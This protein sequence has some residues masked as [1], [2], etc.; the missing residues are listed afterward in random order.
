MALINDIIKEAKNQKATNTTKVN[1]AAP[2][3]L[4]SKAAPTSSKVSAPKASAGAT[5]LSSKA[6]NYK[7]SSASGVTNILNKVKESQGKTLTPTGAKVNTGKSLSSVS[8]NKLNPVIDETLRKLRPQE[9][10]SAELK[11]VTDQLNSKYKISPYSAVYDPETQA[12]EK[13]RNELEN[14][15]KL[16]DVKKERITIPEYQKAYEDAMAKGDKESAKYYSEMVDALD[17]NTVERVLKSASAAGRN[18]F[19]DIMG[20][21]EELKDI[22]YEKDALGYEEQYKRALAEGKTE[23]AEYYKK[24][25]EESRKRA[26]SYD[27]LDESHWAVQLRNESQ[28][29]ME[30]E[31]VGAS[32]TDMLLME[33]GDNVAN[34]IPTV[35]ASAIP[36]VGSFSMA[37]FVPQ[38]FSSVYANNMKNGYDI[39]TSASNAALSAAVEFVSEEIGAITGFAI[40]NT[41]LNNVFSKV[42]DT[43]VG[44]M[45]GAMMANSVIQDPISEGNEELFSGVIQPI[46]DHYTLG[47]DIEYSFGDLS[48]AWIMGALTSAIMNSPQVVTTH[49]SSSRQANFLKAE[50]EMIE[51]TSSLE[52]DE[53]IQATN[54]ARRVAENALAEF[55]E[56]SIT[57]SAIKLESE[58]AEVPSVNE[59]LAQYAEFMKPTED[60]YQKKMQESVARLNEYEQ[61]RLDEKGINLNS[62]VWAMLDSQTKQDIESFAE[63][64]LDIDYADYITHDTDYRKAMVEVAQNNILSSS[65]KFD[66]GLYASLNGKTQDAVKK[67]SKKFNNL[68]KVNVAFDFFKG[69]ES[70]MNAKY[71]RESNSIIVNLN[72]TRAIDIDQLADIAEE[73]YKDFAVN[74][75]FYKS[76]FAS[77]FTN[78]V[79]HEFTHSAEGTDEY[80]KVVELAK[81]SMGTERFERAKSRLN[82][83]YESRNADPGDNSEIIAHYIQKNV[84]SEDFIEKLYKYN[85]SA[86]YR[87][88]DNMLSLLSGNEKTRLESTLRRAIYKANQQNVGELGVQYSAGLRPDGSRKDLRAVHNLSEDKL[89]KTLELGGM[90]MPSIAVSKDS[91]AHEGFGDISVVFNKD[92]IDPANKDNP[93]Y[94]RD[95]WT[96]MFPRVE[97]RP[98]YDSTDKL[99]SNLSRIPLFRELSRN[100][101]DMRR[102]SDPDN[103]EDLLERYDGNPIKAFKDN[104]NMKLLFM[105]ENGELNNVPKT[106]QN[107]TDEFNNDDAKALIDRI[108]RDRVY[109][110]REQLDHAPYKLDDSTREELRTIF[111]DYFEETYGE[112][113]LYDETEFKHRVNKFLNRFRSYL[114]NPQSLSKID[115]AAIKSLAQNVDQQTYEAWLRDKFSGLEIESGIRNNKEIFTPSGNRRSF[116]QTHDD[117]NADNVLKYMKGQNQTGDAGVLSGGFNSVIGAYQ[118][119]FRNVND[120]ISEENRLQQETMYDKIGGED[121]LYT[122]LKDEYNKI[123]SQIYTDAMSKARSTSVDTSIYTQNAIGRAITEFARSKNHSLDNLKR[124][125][126]DERIEVSDENAKALIDVLERTK[127]ITTDYFEAKPRRIV[128][129]NEWK[130][131]YAPNTTDPKLLNQLREM[132]V[133]VI[134]YDK[135]IPGDRQAK[136]NGEGGTQRYQFSIG[137]AD[138]QGRELSNQ[139]REFFK[140]SKV[141]DDNGNLLEMYHGTPYSDITAFKKGKAGYLGPGIYLTSDKAIAKRYASQMGDDGNI[142]SLYANVTNPFVVTTDNPAKEILGDRVYNNRA[143]KQGSMYSLI[144]NA[145]INKLKRMG[146]D[147]IVWKYAGSVEVNAFA[148]EQIK[149]VD[150]L[151]PTSNKDIRYSIGI[152]DSQGRELSPK[153]RE[154]FKDS[155]A[156]DENGNLLTLY[157]GTK[158]AGFTVFNTSREVSNRNENGEWVKENGF[159]PI[160]LTTSKADADSYGGNDYER[161]SGFEKGRTF[162]E[163]MPTEYRANITARDILKKPS[164]YSSEEVFRMIQATNVANN[165]SED[166]SKRKLMS[167]L[168]DI[169]AN[170]DIRNVTIASDVRNDTHA[171]YEMYA[172][173]KNPYVVDYK[174]ARASNIYD[175]EKARKEG[176][177]GVISRNTRVGRYG[178]LGTV[179]VAFSPEQVKLVSNTDPTSSNDIRYSMGVTP[180]TEAEYDNA[181]KNGDTETAGRIVNRV[182]S[183]IPTIAKDSRGRALKLYHG[184]PRFG[185]TEFADSAHEVPF[186]YTSTASEVSAHYAG[187]QN[188]AFRRP[189]GTKYRE[190]N[191]T[192]DI[193]ENAK[194]VLNRDLSLMTD[195]Q[196]EKAFNEVRE[197]AV[198]IADKLDGEYYI[199]FDDFYEKYGSEVANAIEWIKNLFWDIRDGD[200]QYDFSEN[201]ED[202]EE[203]R[204]NLSFDLERYKDNR[205]I[206]KDFFS[207]HYSELNNDEKE[208]IQYLLGFEVGDAAIYIESRMLNT[209]TEED[210]LTDKS[211]QVYIPSNLKKYMDATHNIGSYELYG[212]LG[213]NPFEFDANGAQWTDLKIPE[214]GDGYYSTDHVSKWAYDNGYSSVIMHNIR[215]YGDKA[216]NYV[217]FDSSQLKSADPVTYDDQ[218]NVIPLNERF[219]SSKKDIRYSMG[220]TNQSEDFVSEGIKP[221]QTERLK[222][223]KIPAK[224]GRILQKTYDTFDQGY[225]NDVEQF[226]L[227]YEDVSDYL[228][229]AA[230]EVSRTG[231]ISED[232]LKNIYNLMYQGATEVYKTGERDSNAYD[233]VRD[234]LKKHPLSKNSIKELHLSKESVKDMRNNGIRF[235]NGGADLGELESIFKDNGIELDSRTFSDLEDFNKTLSD[236]RLE[237]GNTHK[238]SDLSEFQKEFDEDFDNFFNETMET[239]IRDITGDYKLNKKKFN[240]KYRYR[241]LSFEDGAGNH[242]EDIKKN[243]FRGDDYKLHLNEPT[244]LEKGDSVLLI[245]SRYG[246]WGG[247]KEGFVPKDYEIITADRD[248]ENTDIKDYL[249]SKYS[250]EYDKAHGETTP[251][252]T[253]SDKTAEVIDSLDIPDEEFFRFVKRDPISPKSLERIEKYKSQLT[254]TAK[255]WIPNYDIIQEKHAEFT[256][257]ELNDALFEILSEGTISESTANRIKDNLVQGLG[258]SSYAEANQSVKEL[259]DDALDYFK[260][261]A[262]YKM[263]KKAMNS[264]ANK[265]NTVI[266]S[267]TGEQSNMGEAAL[268]SYDQMEKLVKER[269]A[270]EKRRAEVRAKN[271]DTIKRLLLEGKDVGNFWATIEQNLDNMAGENKDLLLDLQDLFLLP[272][273][274]AQAKMAEFQQRYKNRLDKI[275]NET[276]FTGGSKESAAAQYLME[277]RREDGSRYTIKDAM[278]QFPDSWEKIEKAAKDLRAMYDDAYNELEENRKKAYGDIDAE[279]DL[280]LAKAREKASNARKAADEIRRKLSE[281]ADP[282]L[283]AMFN[284]ADAEANKLQRQYEQMVNDKAS[285]DSKRRQSLLYKRNYA[286]HIRN[287]GNF[288]TQVKD[289]L[290]D[291]KKVKAKDGSEV[292][293]EK[294]KIPTKLSGISN[295][296]KPL[297]RFASFFMR[298]SRNADYT[299]DAI[300]GMADYINQASKVYGYDPFIEEIRLINNDIRAEADGSDMS[301]WVN[302]LDNYANGIA[303]KTQSLDRGVRDLTDGKFARLFRVLNGAIKSNA[304]SGNLSTALVQFANLPNGLGVITHYG[305]KESA[306]DIARGMTQ[307]LTNIGKDGLTESSPFMNVRYFDIDTRKGNVFSRNARAVSKF[308]LET[309]DHEAAKMIWNIAYQQALRKGEANPVFYADDLTRRSIAGR[310]IGELPMAMENQFLKLINPFQVETNNAYQ[311]FKGLARDKDVASMMAIIIGSWLMNGLYEAIL[312]RRP[313][314]DVIDT[315]LDAWDDEDEETDIGTKL[316]NT[317]VRIGGEIISAMP[318]GSLVFGMA[319][320]NE[321]TKKA[322]FG[323]SDPTRYGNGNIGL[324]TISSALGDVYNAVNKKDPRYLMNAGSDLFFNYVTPGGGRQIQR[325]IEGLQSEGIL[326]QYVNGE[327]V[328][329]PKYYT[330]S[331]KVGFVND[332]NDIFDVIAAGAFGKWATKA[333]REYINGGSKY[334]SDQGARQLEALGGDQNAYNAVLAMRDIKGNGEKNSESLMKR[335]YL[336]DMGL[337]DTFASNMNGE[338]SDY[339][340]GK[341]VGNATEAEFNEMFQKAFGGDSMKLDVA[342]AIGAKPE[343]D[344]EK[345]V[346]LSRFAGTPL[347]KAAIQS[348]DM[349]EDVLKGVTDLG[350][351]YKTIKQIDDYIDNTDSLRKEDGSAIRNTKALQMRQQYEELGIYDDI[352][353]YI[354]ENGLDPQDY[355]LNKTVMGYS[356]SKFDSQ[357]S[358]YFGGGSGGSSG[359]KKSSKKSSSRKSSK[360]SSKKTQAEKDQ[361]FFEK[362]VAQIGT[363]RSTSS[364]IK[365]ILKKSK[366]L[367]KSKGNSYEGLQDLIRDYYKSHPGADK[368]MFS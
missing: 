195:Q 107:I 235:E 192:S 38:V 360:K 219:D 119:N 81:Q 277:G 114:A 40:K 311:T 348:L 260:A 213:D 89:R 88:Y 247:Y 11:S 22:S 188:Y 205:E 250:E 10:T 313:L 132:G 138:S 54:V 293:L 291:G 86:F 285:G 272:K 19:A 206:L 53:Y 280:R 256:E 364:A 136:M 356:D 353:E 327:V 226:G 197:E 337:W 332:P 208:Y 69:N 66:A 161:E 220:L 309:G 304:I 246:V 212:D 90:V 48:H 290:S 294:G 173:I 35:A 201:N 321:N 215:D 276:G 310:E 56:K 36:G 80:D 236:M 15:S 231:G 240:Q 4:A 32:G 98:T 103:F 228:L 24:R 217:F 345:E 266:R 203:W 95:A 110:L 112:S 92:T 135:N 71:D 193:I 223:G 151:N 128:R 241:L 62:G 94:K 127:D 137:I 170:N 124:K 177:D 295:E 350:Y 134:E 325:T 253:M 199:P 85:N 367:R 57:A 316:F 174:G 339:G 209:A 281:K 301:K 13:R 93:V 357:Y 242:I 142:H 239:F 305:G 108:G 140:E 104:D 146:Y 259:V 335:K 12:L 102:L 2:M 328:N 144:T 214:I 323:D 271:A 9:E 248:V 286:H 47:T 287:K 299:P 17:D 198:K 75:I 230:S 190:G 163:G 76:G 49:I 176:Y 156:V 292:I 300:G 34:M 324:S 59:L 14:E 129:P 274:E 331:G 207:D 7:P 262:S 351:D 1:K 261:D 222:S 279:Y 45:W 175:I 234:L 16:Q 211:G 42:M 60:A 349:D 329:D 330:P 27:A 167:I 258:V 150:N 120:I 164:A 224:V 270:I 91:I 342:N 319:G 326:P 152:A 333:G 78:A 159:Q 194:W 347:E 184:T 284:R 315:A 344:T 189:I 275:M 123:E 126:A 204:K 244:N 172:D 336:E 58:Q 308:L 233:K 171:T 166:M 269:K 229:E 96:P 113:E 160:F 354:S 121:P 303:G 254:E 180:Q 133:E 106:E 143:N 355:G 30:L 63:K 111:N 186:I 74:D 3:G 125:F 84:D 115:T 109:D 352:F 251:F 145:D 289:A 216:D 196:K 359:G 221:E 191:S 65:G 249:Y 182:A 26:D 25:A 97:Y 21:V 77:T 147:G 165:A 33:V 83:Y 153:Q 346:D 117:Y 158:D 298:Q 358:K 18:A 73:A 283:E 318:A 6:Q 99:Y 154:F 68:G 263:D 131:V 72:Q 227:R 282:K 169:A 41:P 149:R 257:R 210:R 8:K 185:F 245:P 237:D 368:S 31:R 105:S 162:E 52:G 322:M 255:E 100:D 363:S 130:Q 334:L 55:N 268:D 37:V 67:I 23:E 50:L 361:A 178:E 297:T 20:S 320:F 302:Y 341:T 116:K 200:Y 141:T 312:N 264:V 79:A 225:S 288:F 179:V 273:F 82:E 168:K 29:I 238:A 314:P 51:E 296:S 362:L 155:K 46:I 122:E 64:K 5:K 61:A 340:I 181:V 202:N 70:G 157:H 183:S 87:I 267:F 148:S 243:G 39:Q 187:D 139:Q 118:G 338:W 232:T 343:L 365:S 306:V 43:S 28:H 252:D 317:G 278:E 101:T 366:S 265:A 307:Y 218:G 44:R